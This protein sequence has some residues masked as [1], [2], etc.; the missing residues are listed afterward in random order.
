MKVLVVSVLSLLNTIS[1]A[2]VVSPPLSRRAQSTQ[3]KSSTSSTDKDDN[4]I[5]LGLT[6]S[7]AENKKFMDMLSNHESLG[8]LAGIQLD[9]VVMSHDDFA[10]QVDVVDIAC[11]SSPQA[12]DEWLE[13]IDAIVDG[14]IDADEKTNGNVVAVCLS[15][16]TANAC[17]QSERWESRNIYYPKGENTQIELWVNS[18][19][20]ALGDVME[21]KFWGGGW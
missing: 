14:V 10:N 19:V 6:S 1:F 16:D 11:F 3:Q 12:V 4:I 2:F 20:Q 21:R 7:E 8:M 9:S 13:N 18:C 17:L 15:K 5:T